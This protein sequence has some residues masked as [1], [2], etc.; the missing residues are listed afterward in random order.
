[1]LQ[2]L[3]IIEGSNIIWSRD[4]TS[5]EACMYVIVFLRRV[6]KRQALYQ[7]SATF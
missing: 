5:H 2:H 4:L 6:V 7:G 1:M 3:E